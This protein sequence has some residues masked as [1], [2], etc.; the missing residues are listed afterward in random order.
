MARTALFVLLILLVTGCASLGT[1]TLY[2]SDT[3]P[4]ISRVGYANLEGEAIVT[5]LFPQTSRVY[6]R[7]L[8]ETFS[9]YNINEVIAAGHEFSVKDPD[10]AVIKKVCVEKG[11][12]ALLVTK[13]KFIRMS[14]TV[15][16]V[17]V[18]SNWDTEVEMKLFDSTG[19]LLLAVTHNTAKGNSYFTKPTADR[20][21]HDGIEGA[22]TRIAKELGLPK[23]SD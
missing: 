7:T 23:I 18:S 12:N 1:K 16:F 4:V 19:S 21:I 10:T 8:T 9:N 17:P 13:I 2:R 15:Y 14:Y 22:L 20:T 6:S 3:K 11:L 5:K